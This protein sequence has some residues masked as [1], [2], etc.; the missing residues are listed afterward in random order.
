[1][2]LDPRLVER[3]VA[4]ATKR[5]ENL[6]YFFDRLTS[7]EWI[8]PLR[9][10]R[11]FSEP[12][13]QYV[14]DQNYVRVPGWS[15]SRYLARVAKASP[16]LVLEVIASI[17]TNN[18]RVQ[19]DFVDAAL[20]MP[21][22]QAR[23]VA[24]RLTVW[25]GERDHL[26]YL[27]PRKTVDLVCRLA[28]DDAVAEAIDLL[29]VLFA[30]Q[31]DPRGHG[32]HA[33]LGARFSDWEYD[34][35]LRKVVQDALPHAP[36]EFLVALLQLLTAALTKL[37]RDESGGPRDD[38]SR[39]WRVR[40]ADD[41]DRSS[42]VEEALTSAVRD[43]A[44]TVRKSQLLA[45]DEVVRLLAARPEE[46]IRRI[47][48]YAL[49][50]PPEPDLEVVLLYVLNLDELTSAEPSPEFRELLTAT[51]TRLS[52]T[53][54]G[55]LV[56]AIERGPDV[57]RYRERA[58]RFGER[59]PTA[60]EVA[61][62]VAFWRI[63]RLRLLKEALTGD[64]LA[65]YQNLV[66]KH[67]EAEIPLSWEVHVSWEG[68]TSP[69]SVEELADKSD[70]ELLT[71]LHEW[72]PEQ[73]LGGPSVEG[74]AQAV[75]EVAQRDPLRISRLAPQ[76]RGLR[77]VYVQWLLHGV[78]E[79]IREGRSFDWS[80]LLD[81]LTWVAA[82]PR[83]V[84][85]GRGGDYS[86]SDPGWVWARREVAALLEQGLN[87]RGAY[88]MPLQDRRR[89]W[90]AIA[91]ISE[92][93]DPTPEHEEQYGGHNM[94]PVTLS[95]NTT[96]PKGLQAAVAYAVWLYHALTPVD[97]QPSAAFFARAPE[98]PALVE[99]HLDP[100][101]DPSV[102]VRAVFGR[103]FA[104]LLA[105][106][107][108]WAA[109]HA[110]SIFPAEDTALREAAWGSYVLYTPPYNNV[111]DVLRPVYLRSA[112]LAGSDDRRFDWMNAGPAAKLGEHLTTFYWRGVITLD[113]ELLTTYWRNATSAAR[114]HTVDFLGRSVHEA[115]A[116]TDDVQDRL[117]TFWTSA[118][119]NTRPGEGAGELAGFVWWFASNGL[120][121][122]WRLQQMT[123]LLQAGVQPKAEFLIADTLSSL[124][125]QHPLAAAQIL[126]LWL[127]RGEPWT[128]DAHRGQ[129]ENVLRTAYQAENPDARRVV[130][131]TANWLGA[132]GFR[133]FRFAVQS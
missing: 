59:P 124:A 71:Y 10:R 113:D 60:E 77:P 64:A 95:L 37:R 35:L 120:P 48:M 43:A 27:L 81:L 78:Q 132:K 40:V 96:R 79:A 17:D 34:Q 98:V 1:V 41:S 19:E 14:D 115:T 94:D 73:H 112:E 82:Q 129:I 107:R 111:L 102:A 4:E 67:G 32:W 36:A 91:A 22:R 56:E 31:A 83:E 104:N 114:A 126:R 110:A 42:E 97:Q 46:L 45:D 62:Y 18:E 88:A 93:P 69:L 70:D 11:F 122:E 118:R 76:L 105:L 103:S 12:P 26:Y 58:T 7:P 52:S 68:S 29:S 92:D 89:V 3:A 116:L 9:E 108:G 66:A 51:S 101:D 90:T 30:P 24:K 133:Q 53:Q 121:V 117:V 55:M 8:T 125:E 6:D 39:I 80:S 128:V 50:Q 57:E 28:A 72:E 15:A 131:E 123:A 106:D 49:S 25:L 54:L 61:S 13:R 20:A 44:V 47:T 119:E 87:A 2:A 109:A 5:T 75:A 84:V 86:D 38:A 16:D 33:R 100:A 85:G 21:A 127:E 99:A 63:G 130:E 74:L 23:R 65:S